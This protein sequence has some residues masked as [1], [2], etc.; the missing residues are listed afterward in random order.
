MTGARDQQRL[1]R[2]LALH[3]GADIDVYAAAALDDTDVGTTRA[4]LET[5]YDQHLITEHAA[6]RYRCTT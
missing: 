1:F 5:L 6:G 3:D 2:R 4:R